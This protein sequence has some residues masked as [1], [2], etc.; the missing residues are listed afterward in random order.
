MKTA[1]EAGAER[2]DEDATTQRLNEVYSTEPSEAD[3]VIAKIAAS[4]LPRESWK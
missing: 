2:H 1:I 3:P 4:S